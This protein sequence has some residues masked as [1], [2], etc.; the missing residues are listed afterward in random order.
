MAD[1]LTGLLPG[2]TTIFRTPPDASKQYRSSLKNS[3][4]T[5]GT[6]GNGVERL[7]SFNDNLAFEIEYSYQPMNK[8]EENA[9]RQFFFDRKGQFESFWAPSWVNEFTLGDPATDGDS[10]L[11]CVDNRFKFRGFDRVFLLLYSGD[12]ITRQVT[13]ASSP[14]GGVFNIFLDTPIDRDLQPSEIKNFGRLF[15][16][17]FAS[18][19][20]SKKYRS[21]IVS[22]VSFRL[23][24]LIEEY[25]EPSFEV[26]SPT[27]GLVW[28]TTENREILWTSQNYAGTVRIELYKAGVFDS[29]IVASTIDS[30]S[31][32]W[33][34]PQEQTPGN[35]YQI[36]VSAAGN[37]SIFDL[38][39]NFE[40]QKLPEVVTILDPNGGEV[41]QRETE[42]T[43][44]WN[45][46]G[47]FEDV[48]IVLVFNTGGGGPGLEEFTIGLFPYT[49]TSFNWLVPE[50]VALKTDY[51]I[52]ADVQKG[53][54]PF[55]VWDLSDA[56][57]EITFLPRSIT[58]TSSYGEK[59]TG[60]TLTV[61]WNSTNMEETENV[62]VQ[63]IRNLGPGFDF[64]E[65]TIIVPNTGEAQITLLPT[66]TG[67][68][69]IRVERI[70]TTS[71]TVRDESN[72]FNIV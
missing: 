10:F 45:N 55:Q 29:L 16:C 57:F 47:F 15:L 24:E 32:L 18:D 28:Q 26:T 5:L 53:G 19:T 67:M 31:Y 33:T 25:N 50:T 11:T 17:R 63:Q 66:V 36:F 9:V 71:G 61:N 2:K 56:E 68:A 43:I 70:S 38:S 54:A 21:Y 35:D 7:E 3:R 46:Q 13:S 62:R 49:T 30:G 58:V 22:E 48:E 39:D 69:K 44:S 60:E 23:I 42:V 64:V 4:I 8:E 6:R 40:I 41:I 20:L 37:T 27:I 52:R 59:S 14:V 34:I 65:Q 51:K 72:L 1:S 12:L